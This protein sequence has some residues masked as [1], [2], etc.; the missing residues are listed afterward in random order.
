MITFLTAIGAWK[1]R[2]GAVGILTALFMV[3]KSG[4]DAVKNKHNEERSDDVNKA[5]YARDELNHSVGSRLKLRK[6]FRPNR[7]LPPP[8]RK[9]NLP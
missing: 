4:A 3:R 7:R 8:N 1:Y 6:R 9:N 2:I 5:K